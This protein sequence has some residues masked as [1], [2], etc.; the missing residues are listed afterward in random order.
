V[1]LSEWAK[2]QGITYKTAWKWFQAGKLPVKAEQMPT[3]TIIVFPADQAQ[4]KVALYARVSSADQ[5]T[6]LDRQIA[7]LVLYASEKQLPISQ[8]ITEIGSGLNG[9][10]PKLLRL[11]RDESINV[12]LVEHRDRLMRFGCEY[13]EAALSCQGRRL[14]IVEESEVKDDLVRDMIEVLTSFCARLYGR[15]AGRNKAK[16]AMEA[17]RNEN[18]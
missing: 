18:G 1:K 11:L 6:D 16:K 3:G 12:I 4:L 2:M 10:R 13:L 14:M 8:T 15:R 9:H 7:R 5:K 17:I